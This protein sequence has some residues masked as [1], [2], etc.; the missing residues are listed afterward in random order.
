M[1]A[2]DVVEPPEAARWKKVEADGGLDRGPIRCSARASVSVGSV[3]SCTNDTRGSIT[4]QNK[5]KSM[6][7]KKLFP[8]GS[9]CADK[10]RSAPRRC[11]PQGAIFFMPL[12]YI[13]FGLFILPRLS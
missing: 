6:A 12:I 2:L 8:A 7:Q 10:A 11:F 3:W 4:N 13:Y 1:R 9:A 5:Y